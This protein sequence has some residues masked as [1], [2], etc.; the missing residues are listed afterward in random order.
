MKRIVLIVLSIVLFGYCLAINP[1]ASVLPEGYFQESED[2][3]APIVSVPEILTCVVGENFTCWC[4]NVA[5]ISYWST[6]PTEI[7]VIKLGNNSNFDF[8]NV[9]QYA[10]SQWSSA[11]GFSISM[12]RE[13]SH[14]DSRKLECFGGTR[15]DLRDCGAFVSV[16]IVNPGRTEIH[17]ESYAESVLYSGVYKTVYAY[18]KVRMYVVE[19]TSE[20]ELKHVCLHEL[21]HALGWRGHSS[22]VNDVMHEDDSVTKT[23]LTNRDKM[24][25]RQ[26]YDIM[27]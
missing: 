21:G 10:I 17:S 25:L 15:N 18:N 11:L 22:N 8:H 14:V 27:G 24:H 2:V 13:S 7:C 20:S 9:M 16:D 12:K 4:T 5:Y 23:V 1:V 6:R 3:M 26:V 19:N